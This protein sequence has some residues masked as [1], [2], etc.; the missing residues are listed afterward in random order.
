MAR[1][2]RLGLAQASLTRG[3]VVVEPLPRRGGRLVDEAHGGGVVLVAAH[4]AQAIGLFVEGDLV[5]GQAAPLGDHDAVEGVD[6]LQPREVSA[7]G[8]QAH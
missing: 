3:H 2:D 1:G 6:P 5:L 4:E 8:R 7:G